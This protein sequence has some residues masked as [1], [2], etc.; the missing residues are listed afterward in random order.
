MSVTQDNGEVKKTI[1]TVGQGWEMPE[2]GDEVFVHYVG[3]LLDGTKFDSSRDRG[4]P[5]SFK[6]GTGKAE[7]IQYG[8]LQPMR[9]TNQHPAA[10]RKLHAYWRP[11]MHTQQAT[12]S[13]DGTWE[14]QP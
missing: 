14:W 8:G 11:H 3:T 7:V 12:S 5:F 10:R 6:L 13:G 2:K 1:L 4:Q 9:S